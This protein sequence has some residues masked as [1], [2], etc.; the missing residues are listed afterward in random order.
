VIDLAG[1]VA[2]AREALLAA[3]VPADEAAGDAEVLARHALQWDLTQYTLARREPPPPGFQEEFDRL[4]ARRIAR[5]PV[6]QIV[7]VP[8]Q[9]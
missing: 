3:G 4:I 5:E 2:Q 6:L 1:R 7:E 9:L 8:T